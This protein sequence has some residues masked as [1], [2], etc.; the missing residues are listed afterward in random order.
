MNETDN[1]AFACPRCDKTP[2]DTAAS[3][4]RC[5]GCKVDFPSIAGIP[6]LFAEP[7]ATLGEWRGRLHYLLQS[8]EHDR[9]RYQRG[10]ESQSI[11]DLT[12]QRLETMAT[13]TAEHSTRLRELLMP[14]ELDSP[15]ATQETYL[16]LRTKLPLD[17]GLTTY[18][19]NIH[20]D[21]SWGQ[22]ENDLSLNIVAEALTGQP[23]G[24]TLVLGAGAGRLAHDIHETLAPAAT[25]AL[26]FNPLLMLLAKRISDGGTVELYEFPIAPKDI[27]HQAKL[28]A[29]KAAKPAR[30]GLHYCLADVH[31]PPFAKK[32][33]DTIVTPWLVDILPEQFSTLCGRINQLLAD[34][35]RWMNF[36]S[37]SFHR[38]D[39]ALQFSREECMEIVES[40]GFDTPDCRDTE[41]PYLCS[42][43]SRHS[44]RECV[45]G[46]VT[47][48]REHLKK[49]ARH[50]SLPDWLVR[51]KEPVPQLEHFVAQA[52]STRIHAFIM[53]LIDGRRSLID[54]AKVLEEQR[55]MTREEAEPA[56]RSFLIKMYEES[57][58]RSY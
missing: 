14:L 41:I 33:F 49:V 31:R 43:A 35:G 21:W 13:A 51:G 37:L 36:G 56:I 34:G 17:Q 8:L 10:A 4:F 39:P 38:A 3:G 30:A 29:L 42:P 44:R 55:L 28:R 53:S 9:D 58:R 45:L 24:N 22:E 5:T 47:T 15:A 54:M 11:L 18:Y 6:W 52:M 40:A 27:S 2:L 7:Q 1:L 48:K 19:S 20:R 46:W 25:F 16:A 50:E 57:Q 23:L 12:R 32:S 26:D